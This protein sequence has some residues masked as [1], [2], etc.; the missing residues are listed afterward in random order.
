MLADVRA[1][2]ILLYDFPE[3]ICCQMTRLTLAEKG[4]S[5][6]CQTVDIM[7]AAEQFEPWYTALNPKAVVPTVWRTRYRA[8]RGTKRWCFASPGSV[9]VIW[10]GKSR[11]WALRGRIGKARRTSLIGRSA[12]CLPM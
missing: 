12:L 1:A 4:V 2:K 11:C 5:Y 6:E 10:A 7:E 9:A 3:S 8:F